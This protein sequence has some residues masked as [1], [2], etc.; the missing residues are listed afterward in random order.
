M[1]PG[2]LDGIEQMMDQIQMLPFIVTFDVGRAEDRYSALDIAD[3][4]LGDRNS[5]LL[6][7]LISGCDPALQSAAWSMPF[8]DVCHGFRNP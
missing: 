5:G 4:H 6:H 2:F 7:G 1:P 3:T 8:A